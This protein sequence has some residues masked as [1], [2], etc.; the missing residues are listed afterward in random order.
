MY[1]KKPEPTDDNVFRSAPE[2]KINAPTASAW[3]VGVS[4]FEETARNYIGFGVS[5][6]LN[7]DQIYR[8]KNRKIK[9]AT[10]EDLF[11]PQQSIYGLYYPWMDDDA[12]ARAAADYETYKTDGGDLGWGGFI[13]DRWSEKEWR[14]RAEKA[15][16]KHPELRDEILSPATI[17]EQGLQ[18]GRDASQ[19]AADVW[20]QSDKGLGAWTGWLGGGLASQVYDPAFYM[21]VPL[22]FGGAGLGAKGLL[23]GAAKAAGIN[24]ASQAVVEPSIA[25]YQTRMGNEYGL[26]EMVTSLAFAGAFG[27]GVDLVGRGAYRGVARSLGF[28]PITQNGIVVAWRRPKPEEAAA[29]PLPDLPPELQ[30]RLAN[31]DEAAQLEALRLYGLD[32]AIPDAVV[33]RAEDGDMASVSQIFAQDA[34]ADPVLRQVLEAAEADEPLVVKPAPD[35]PDV[36]HAVAIRQALRAVADPEHEP[37]PVRVTDDPIPAGNIETLR[38]DLEALQAKVAE[39]PDAA[40][41]QAQIADLQRRIRNVDTFGRDPVGDALRLREQPEI[42]TTDMDLAAPAVQRVRAL[43]SLTDEAFAMVREGKVSPAIGEIVADFV[44]RELQARAMGDLAQRKPVSPE[45]ARAAVA[46]LLRSPDYTVKPTAEPGAVPK[47]AGSPRQID[48]PYGAEAKAQVAALEQKFREEMQAVGKVAPEAID[49]V[50]TPEGRVATIGRAQMVEQAIADLLPIA[51]EGTRLRVFDRVDELPPTLAAQVRAGNAVKFQRALRRFQQAA[52]VPERLAAAKVL[53]SAGRQQGIDGIAD[54]DTIWIAAAAMSPRATFAHEVVHA[55]R[56][57]GVLAPEE[58]KLLAAA[59][60]ESEA[61]PLATEQLYRDAY[62][63]QFQTR[64]A[65]D[66]ILDE[67]AAAHY[68]EAAVN[69]RLPAA[70]AAQTVA[71]GLVDR[72]RDFLDRIREILTGQGYRKA[73]DDTPVDP[74]RDVVDALLAGEIAKREAKAEW[75]R[76]NP[77]AVAILREANKLRKQALREFMDEKGYTAMALTPERMAGEPPQYG[78]VT[79]PDGSAS[80]PIQYEIVD[81]ATLQRAEG[82]LQPRDRSQRA[83][84]DAQ[85]ENIAAN[86][87]GDLLLYAPQSDRGAPIVDENN[88][89]LS[90]N[91]RRAALELAKRKHPDKYQAYVD[92]L[93]RE[94]FNVDGME[95][96]VLV[97]RLATLDDADKRKFAI[98]SNKDDKLAMSPSEQARV[99]RDLMT[100]D[101]LMR[102]DPEGEA[103]LSSAS[104]RDF[105]RA[106]MGKIAPA[107]RAAFQAEDGSL[108]PAGVARLEAGI[109]ARAYDDRTL[110]TRIV[111][112]QDAPGIRNAL[113]GAA[114]AWAQMR[115]VSPE[116]DITPNLVEAVGILGRLRETRVK[117]DDYFAQQDAFSRVAPET[118]TIT[119]LFFKEDGRRA[120]WRDTRDALKEYARQASDQANAVGDLL[121]AKPKPR[122]ILDGEL[123]KLRGDMDGPALFKYVSEGAVDIDRLGLLADHPGGS[124]VQAYHATTA[125]FDQFDKSRSQDFGVHFGTSKQAD[126]I[127]R[128]GQTPLSRALF[129]KTK[130]GARTLPVT[131]DIKNPIT[132]PDLNNWHP[133]QMLKEL[134]ARGVEFDDTS[135]VNIQ[136]MADAGQR[137]AAY[138]EIEN[139]LNRAGYDGI[140]YRNGAEGVGWSYIVWN[141]GQVRSAYDPDRVLFAFAGENARSADMLKLGMAKA[142]DR[143]GMDRTT[144][145]NRTGWFKGVD[146]KWRFETDDSLASM[147]P[148]SR[149]IMENVLDNPELYKAYPDMQGIVANFRRLLSGQGEATGQYFHFP[150]EMISAQGVDADELLSI[151]LHELQHAVQAREDFA[152]GGSPTQFGPDEIEAERTRLMAIEDQI[153]ADSWT[154]IG[155]LPGDMTRD[156]VA[157]IR[158]A[159]LAGEVEARTVQARAKLSAAERRVRPPWLDY[160]I[161][162]SAQI[163]RTYG[164]AEAKAEFRAALEKRQAEGVELPGGLKIKGVPLFKFAESGE[165]KRAYHGTPWRFDRFSLASIGTGEG[166]QVYGWGLYF[167]S[168]REI[169]EWYKKNLTQRHVGQARLVGIEHIATLDGARMTPGQFKSTWMRDADSIDELNDSGDFITWRANMKKAIKGTIGLDQRM[170]RE[171]QEGLDEVQALFDQGRINF[172][173]PIKGETLLIDGKPLSAKDWQ[174]A[175]AIDEARGD[176]TVVRSHFIEEAK[177][178]RDAYHLS[179]GGMAARLMDRTLGGGARTQALDYLLKQAKELEGLAARVDAMIKSNAKVDL[180]AKPKGALYEVYLKADDDE[181]LDWDRLIGEQSDYVQSAAARAFDDMGGDPAAVPSLTGA[182][183]VRLMQDMG[184]LGD[185]ESQLRQYGLKGIK[186]LDGMSRGRGDGSHNF[187]IFDEDAIEIQAIDGAPIR[188]LKESALFSFSDEAGAFDQAFVAEKGHGAGLYV[189]ARGGLA[190][191]GYTEAGVPMLVDV[192]PQRTMAWRSWR[193]TPEVRR[194]LDA[195]AV[196][197]GLRLGPFPRGEKVY[198]ALARRLGSDDLATAALREV[199]IQ[200]HVVNDQNFIG[201]VGTEAVGMQNAVVY[202]PELVHPDP[203]ADLAS[204]ETLDTQ[205]ALGFGTAA[206]NWLRQALGMPVKEPAAGALDP[207]ALVARSIE[208]APYFGLPEPPRT[209]PDGDPLLDARDVDMSPERQAMRQRLVDQRFAGKTPATGQKVAILMGGGGASGKGTVLRALRERG[210]IGDEYVELDPD[211]F[212]T[213]DAQHGWDGVPEYWDIV[214]RGDSRAAGVTHE[215]SSLIFKQ[216]M[217][218]ALEGG[219]SVILDRTMGSPAKALAEMQMFKDA[220][221]EI[222]LIGVSVKPAT[223]IMRAVE[224][225][226]GKEKRYVPL[227]DLLTAHKGFSQGFEAYSRVADSV[228]LYDTNFAQPRQIARKDAGGRLE[229]LDKNAYSQF[230]QKGALNDQADTFRQIDEAPQAPAFDDSLMGGRPGVYAGGME[231]GAGTAGSGSRPPGQPGAGGVPSGR[232]DQPPALFAMRNEEGRMK[233]GAER[234]AKTLASDLDEIEADLAAAAIDQ[235]QALQRQRAAYLNA[236]AEEAGLDDLMGYRSPRGQEDVATAFLR[237]HE[238]VGVHGAPFMDLRSQRDLIAREAI[239]MMDEAMWEL[240]KGAFLGDLRRTKNAAVRTRMENMMREAAGEKTGDATAARMA[241]AWLRAAEYLRQRFNANGGDIGKLAGWFAPQYHD[242]ERILR[243]GRE[244]WTSHMM[245]DGVLDRDRMRNFDG[246]RMSNEELRAMLRDVWSTITTDGANKREIGDGFGKGA[247]YK[248]HAEHRVLHFKNADAYLAYVREFGGADPYAMMIGHVQMMARDI[249]ALERFG[250]NPEVVRDRLKQQI[251]IDAKTGRSARSV[252]DDLSD[253]VSDLKKQV[254]GIATPTDKAM[255]RISDLHKRLDEIR[256]NPRRDAERQQLQADLLVANQALTTALQPGTMSPQTQPLVQRILAVMDEMDEIARTQSVL[257]RN[258]EERARRILTRADEMWRLYM[259]HTNVPIDG[260]IAGFL[261]GFRNWVSASM[262]VFAPMSA[263]TD[264]ATGAAARAFVGM[265]VTRQIG[266]FL[267]GFTK[268]DRKFALRAG[269]G[270]DQALHAFATSQRFMGFV[271]T[272]HVTG[273]IADRTHAFSGLAPMTQ[274]AKVG[275]ASDFMAWMA[276]LASTTPWSALEPWTRQMLDRHGF[277]EA[278]YAALQ[279]VTPDQHRGVPVLT[280]QAIERAAGSDVA[281]RYMRVLL[282][283]QAMAVLEPTLQGRTAII[284][285]TKPGT[286]IGEMA[287]SVAML[288][289]FPTSYM[290]LI[291]GRFYN[292]WLSG[293]AFTGNTIAA[294]AAIFVVGTLLGA[295][296]IQLKSIGKG[297]DPQPMDEKEFWLKAFF[298]SGGLGIYGDFI[299]NA[300]NRQ[301]GSLAQTIFGPMA[302]EGQALLNLTLGNAVQYAQGEPSNAGR[303]I[304]QYIRQRTPGAFV[305]WYLRTAYDRML[306]DELQ[307]MVDPEAHKSFRRKIQNQKKLGGNEFYWRP[308]RSAPDRGPDLGA[309]FGSQ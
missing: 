48:D 116:Y 164:K 27:A 11:N 277:S 236:Q 224:R 297:Q 144:I 290:M 305:P 237:M 216:A 58:V 194:A 211:S 54:G 100:D 271:N 121:G 173:G 163:V 240:R 244:A 270:L 181:L 75:M 139:G 227:R 214:E 192:D 62:R 293:R 150:V 221:Y 104:N 34:Q 250:A 1:W 3:D 306:L 26:P 148:R 246:S 98:A 92:V 291:L 102:L 86:L 231:A 220:G 298:Q 249:A 169:A 307:K 123:G 199:G 209:I 101:V 42:L 243:A 279:T 85:I 96:P 9:E 74:A 299:N 178:Q 124:R 129:G 69:D 182:D 109:F 154:E 222:R 252:Y 174:L 233:R 57:A 258:P 235:R 2:E 120:S 112:D 155:N 275:F 50:A 292:Q 266:S 272:A 162:E 301:G 90:G 254:A 188:P 189:S 265:P 187:V 251:L 16:E 283:E 127:V 304:T 230:A 134:Q 4:T 202:D 14:A 49:A 65:L 206:A 8:D 84:S 309:A 190:G 264:Q 286:I 191:Y 29:P 77:Q 149:S 97:R 229:L 204:R 45:D 226:K 294:G 66:D 247:L 197:Y 269:I 130:D 30:E 6:E 87:N 40:D 200:G 193:Q 267:K 238:S 259:G 99:D 280:R 10:G 35:M 302:G 152:Y 37:I 156:Q 210:R 67:E 63:D 232:L 114:P 93:K 161:P 21:S 17:E 132:L 31:Q 135:R 44:P 228:I 167:A 94:G 253:L 145:W 76:N 268:E 133:L 185:G 179:M 262:L 287:R 51:P 196:D 128:T 205:Q 106:V 5:D 215:E 33:K 195:V 151:G 72:I 61:F 285:E 147:G 138:R 13:R 68:I 23:A 52:T 82:D 41:L 165:G 89:V 71:R 300:I 83:A 136:R 103:G 245:Q 225:A 296:A 142:Y 105:V 281:D 212:K 183:L 213:G 140:R 107:E 261:G 108:T 146:G 43:A 278:D 208:E 198:K 53:K 273:Y 295:T 248:R 7:R 39:A 55:L 36:D 115:A 168:S 20:Q 18:L 239:G 80:Y 170:A 260:N 126:R 175:K 234:R 177:Y 241:Q 119:R 47:A 81:L 176:L 12:K 110:T 288:K 153:P 157:M 303:E 255:K 217:R 22:T 257:T 143:G 78:R 79:T 158:Y 137:Q 118:E 64:D 308:G 88:V 276:D 38:R 219:Y 32:D 180:P 274:A 289:S 25:A 223:A 171:M 256:G 184:K 166:A 56:R 172:R 28:E 60:R 95:A 73:A 46:E 24:I 282:R 15:L 284:S 122:E 125:D 113:I 263:I 207:A 203:R 160:D 70:A 91:A 59:A 159:R 186:Y 111:E 19:R 201:S 141:R 242:A 131:L 117:V 218:Q